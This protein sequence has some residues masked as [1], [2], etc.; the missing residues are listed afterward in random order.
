[1][2]GGLQSL[3]RAFQEIEIGTTGFYNIVN[4]IPREGKKK[5]GERSKESFLFKCYTRSL[6]AHTC[7]IILFQLFVVIRRKTLNARDP[8]TFWKTK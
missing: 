5:R 7:L 2:G 4:I 3:Q 1:V 6:L 8:G